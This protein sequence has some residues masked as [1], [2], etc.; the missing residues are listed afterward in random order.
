MISVNFFL[1]SIENH[2]NKSEIQAKNGLKM[3]KPWKYYYFKLILN[4]CCFYKGYELFK[5]VRYVL[6]KPVEAMI[7]IESY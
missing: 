2:R 1:I 5:K 3:K 6:K 7:S 4:M